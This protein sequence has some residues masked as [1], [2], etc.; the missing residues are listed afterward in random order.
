[1]STLNLSIR[2]LLRNKRRSVVAFAAISVGSAAILLFG[3]YSANIQRSMETAY[4]RTGGHLQIQHRD[5]QAFGGGNPTAYGMADYQ[6][7][8]NAL[9]TDAELARMTTLV[10]PTL[11]FGG[12]AGN[13][14][15]GVSRTVMGIGVVATDQTRLREWNG[16]QLP[17]IEP[18]SALDGSP[19]DSAVLGLG[20]A[21]VLQLCSAL[22]VQG[23]PSP[24][25]EPDSGMGTDLPSDIARLSADEAKRGAKI[26]GS[27]EPAKTRVELLAT[28]PRG[29]P[30]VAALAVVS[31]EQ[32]GFKELDDIFLR[33]HLAQGQRLIYGGGKLKATAI[34]VQ[35]HRSV[36]VVGARE[37]ITSIIGAASYP[38]PLAVLDFREINPF[39]VQTIN[40][41]S[42]I[43]GFIFSLIGAIVLFTVMT[44]MNAAV[45]E[46][47][48]EI[49]TLRA[50]GLRRGG[51]RSL[52]ASEGFLLGASGS[53][54]GICVALVVA[55]VVNSLGLTWLPPGS[56]APLPLILRVW[57][58]SGLILGTALGLL[59]VAVVSSWWPAHHASKTS[60]VE[61][62]RH[63]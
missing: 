54:A 26:N 31:A 34:V 6:G 50:I 42:T 16:Y 57:G 47:T 63:V 39:F 11:Q 43:F 27:N 20:L 17:L 58:E 32:Q 14:S 37:R 51:V 46:R 23:C 5:F 40:L 28:G 52:F 25:P 59:A 33:V 48:V 10:T 1:M 38:Q 24:V 4:V 36:D 19:S 15:A 60:I 29:A 3:G 30:N 41:F 44:T 18:K 62:L 56:A 9:R 8:I 2:N 53:L 35:L 13:Y 7:L 21:R 49:G 61:A 45:V 12:I 22:S 55:A